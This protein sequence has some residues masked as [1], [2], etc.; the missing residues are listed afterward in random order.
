M[1]GGSQQSS[2]SL[3]RTRQWRHLPCAGGGISQLRA[4]ITSHVSSGEPVRA[5]VPS[6]YKEPK[7]RPF[8]F[9]FS[10]PDQEASP[11]HSGEIAET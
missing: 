4:P 3:E 8:F 5:S 2:Y 10:F 7:D 6:L 9:L 1:S 11:G